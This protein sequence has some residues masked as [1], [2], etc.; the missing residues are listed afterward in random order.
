MPFTLARSY[1]YA[2]HN[3]VNLVNIYA[4]TACE[5]KYCIVEKKDWVVTRDVLVRN[6]SGQRSIILIGPLQ[7][8]NDFAGMSV[9]KPTY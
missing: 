9:Y 5:F 3:L 8:D 6:L 1:G 7:E 2:K 4:V